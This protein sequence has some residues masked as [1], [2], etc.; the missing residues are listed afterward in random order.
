MYERATG[1]DGLSLWQL[2]S[3]SEANTSVLTYSVSERVVM[4]WHSCA[5]SGGLTVPRGLPDPWRCGTEGCGQW[6]ILD[7]WTR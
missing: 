2:V 6:A 7:G 4:H 1:L 5:G 3:V